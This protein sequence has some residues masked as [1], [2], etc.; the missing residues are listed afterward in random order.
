MALV[1]KDEMT[2]LRSAADAYST[3]QTAEYE[4][5]LKAVAFAVNEASNTGETRTMFL[6]KLLDDVKSE[7]ESKGYTVK[8]NEQAA[9]P[10]IQNVISWKQ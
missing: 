4:Q 8:E 5:Q 6:G 3:S 2:T 10:P 7:L 1:P 9:N